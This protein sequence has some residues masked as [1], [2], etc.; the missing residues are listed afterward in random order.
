[1]EVKIK[2]HQRIVI[3]LCLILI[4][5]VSIFFRFVNLAEN[6][7]WYSD[8]GS[9]FSVT[10]N[11]INKRLQ[12]E[13]LNWTFF[14]SYLPQP[15]L[16]FLFSALSILFF[17][18]KL[19]SLR[20]VSAISSVFTTL[21]LYFAGEKVSSKKSALLSSFLFAIYPLGIIYS[22][23]AF[24]Y[25]LSML[26]ITLSIWCSLEYL[27]KKSLFYLYLTSIFVGLASF[28]SYNALPLIF[29]LIY[30]SNKIT[31]A[32]VKEG[33]RPSYFKYYFLPPLIAISFLIVLLLCVF[34]IDKHS[35]IFDLKTLCIRAASEPPQ[36]GILK[37]YFYAI[38]NFFRIDFFIILGTIGLLLASSIHRWYLLLT[39]FFLSLVPFS[40]QGPYIDIFFYPAVLLLPLTF[41]GLA[42]LIERVLNSG[43]KY[44]SRF[45][46][47]FAILIS[48][49]SMTVIAK[50]LFFLFYGF[51][52][53]MNYFATLDTKTVK[54]VAEFVNNN[55]DATD[56]VIAPAYLYHLLNCRYASFFQSVAYEGDSVLFY[57]ANIDKKRF[58][59][60][61]SYKNAKFIVFGHIDKIF[62]LRQ[63]PARILYEQMFKDNLKIVFQ[64]GEFLIY[65]K[66]LP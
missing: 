55:T 47:L 37:S 29:S 57:P 13:A 43:T 18:T 66:N 46:L 3:P 23:W 39:F 20:I 25:N 36:L 44:F 60:D 27:E 54:E 32:Q 42:I 35:L 15:P 64:K 41:L 14:S 45:S 58:Y 59:Y 38:K 24:H 4:L 34:I 56:L 51:R 17:G 19:V 11:L 5:V 49:I 22:R 61:C 53:K 8:E 9:Y 6:P 12:F 50:D 26:F 48:V 65:G 2:H 7:P 40:R 28:S 31:Q 52:H 62:T 21:V 63:K 1:M 16:F 30:L 33:V 10:K